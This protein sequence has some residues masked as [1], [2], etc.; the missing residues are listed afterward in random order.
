MLYKINRGTS[1]TRHHQTS[2]TTPRGHPPRQHSASI[3]LPRLIPLRLAHLAPRRAPP[4]VA[5]PPD[6]ALGGADGRHGG[7]DVEVEDGLAGDLGL[8]RVVVDDVADLLGLAVDVAGDEP[9]VAVK[10][11]LR[12]VES[13]A[14]CG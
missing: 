4:H 9:V 7:P 12:T 1:H 5:P 11:G 2:I 10:G 14:S 13:L 6:E 3:G 8:A